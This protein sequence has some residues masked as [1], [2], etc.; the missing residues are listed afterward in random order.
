M[1]GAAGAPR[2]VLAYHRISVNKRRS[3]QLLALFGL[4]CLPAAAY[5][6]VFLLFAAIVL[7]GVLL[8]AVATGGFQDSHWTV[9]AI[10]VPSLAAMVVLLIPV[11]LFRF[12][13]SVVLRLSGAR[14]LADGE[15]TELR[16]TVENLCIG[17]GL[18]TPALR[19]VD[20]PAANAFSTG[21]DPNHATLVFTSGLPQ[22]LDRLEVEAVIAHE[23]SRIGNYDTRLDTIL[24]AGVAFLRL[25]FAAVIGIFRFL[26]RLH[27]AVGSFFLLYLG[28]PALA[29]V[30]L[31]FVASIDM[32]DED[33]AQAAL[34]LVAMTVPIYS[35]LMAPLLAEVIRASVSRQRRFLADA[36]AVLLARTSEPLALALSKMALAGGLRVPRSTAHLWTVDPLR[37][38]PWWDLIWPDYH[39]PVS[40]RVELIS[41]M[42]SGTT[43]SALE[44]AQRQGEHHAAT[45][46]EIGMSSSVSI[47]SGLAREEDS[48]KTSAGS[49]PKAYRLTGRETLVFEDPDDSS[50]VVSRLPAGTLVTVHSESG[51]FLHVITPED[52]FGH[53][54]R[55]TR[56]EP[57]KVA[58][59][60]AE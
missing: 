23:L 12:A 46:P 6:A 57:V 1:A 49:R 10:V 15:H 38:S 31:G 29:S 47:T 35:L 28:L 50:P 9:W 55:N 3:W 14:Q 2:R 19:V 33:P 11:A 37:E 44:E 8:G 52:R 22:L 58:T 36:D 34:M 27:W 39:P 48:P 30:P 13:T 60:A 18:P 43:G 4:S 59:F 53:I 24:A 17:S 45:H 21:L 56:M 5:V 16:R 54:S 42:G 32:L 40:K 20:S 7:L 41:G 25:P 51:A 26:F